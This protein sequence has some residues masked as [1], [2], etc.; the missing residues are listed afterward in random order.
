MT[1]PEI[2]RHA[3]EVMRK[4]GYLKGKLQDETGAHCALGAIQ[5][6]A[7]PCETRVEAIRVLAETVKHKIP[8]KRGIRDTY[9]R[10]T[11]K[12]NSPADHIV[13]GWNNNRCN[14]AEDVAKCM[15]AAAQIAEM[16]PAKE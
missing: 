6:V 13:F 1:V 15:E 11:V 10:V 4:G 14:S 12:R 5:A 3:A 16:E 2:L 9:N 7:G 8:P